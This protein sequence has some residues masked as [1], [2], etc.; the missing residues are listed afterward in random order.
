MKITLCV[1]IYIVNENAALLVSRFLERIRRATC[2]ETIKENILGGSFVGFGHQ[3]YAI[4]S[5]VGRAL[6]C[7]LDFSLPCALGFSLACALDLLWAKT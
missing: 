1:Y 7:A 2:V 6:A 5:K 3:R 4:T